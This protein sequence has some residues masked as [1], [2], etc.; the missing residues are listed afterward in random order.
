MRLLCMAKYFDTE[1]ESM[2]I[3]ECFGGDENAY[4][5]YFYNTDPHREYEAM[6][7]V[8]KRIFFD[9]CKAN[10]FKPIGGGIYVET[11]GM[12]DFQIQIG[13]YEYGP[14][15]DTVVFSYNQ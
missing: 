5:D 13:R 15:V 14:T 2:T 6:T 9:W 7:I 3:D 12:R 4:M 10:G 8:G 11:D 1:L